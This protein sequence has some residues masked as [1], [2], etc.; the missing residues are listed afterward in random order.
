[1]VALDLMK[2]DATV[3][4]KGNGQKPAAFAKGG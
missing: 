3:D 2:F 4:H 1:M